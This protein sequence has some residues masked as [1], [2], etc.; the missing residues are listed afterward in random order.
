MSTNRRLAV[1]LIATGLAAGWQPAGATTTAGP[2]AVELPGARYTALATPTRIMDTR[3]DVG[4]HPRPVGS[5]ETVTVAVPGV[6]S[7][8]TAVVVNLTGTG[9]TNP[10]YLSAFPDQFA[11]TSTLNLAA[12]ETAA[13]AAV[14]TLGPDRVF[15]VRNNFGT[16]H[17]VVDLVGYLATGGGDGFAAAA[18]PVRILDTRTTTGGHLGALGP[19]QQLTLPVRG[20]A[21]VPATATSV[22]VNLTGVTP[23]AATFLRVTPNGGGGSSTLNLAAGVTRANLAVAAVGS[24]GAIRIGNL[25]GDTHV[26]VDVLGWFAPGAAGRYVAAQKPVRLLD[27]RET[28]G[29]IEPGQTRSTTLASAA[30]PPGGRT[31]ALLNVT[32]AAATENTHLTTWPQGGAQPQT[33]TLNMPAGSIVSN[34]A[35]VEGAGVSVFNN[36]GRVH[37]IVDAAGYFYTPTRAEPAAPGTPT[38][39]QVRNTGSYIQVTWA[40]PTDDGGLPLTRYTVTLEP[41]GR[42]VTVGGHLNTATIE[43]TASGQRYTVAVRATNFVGTGPATPPRATGPS[44]AMTRVDTDSAGTPDVTNGVV[45]KGLSADG[46]YVLLSVESTSILVPEQF[47]TTQPQILYVMRKELPTGALE[48]VGVDETGAPVHH[49]EAVISRDGDTVAY[50]DDA[51]RLY[52]R[53]LAAGTLRTVPASPHLFAL[54]M[55]GDERRLS[56]LSDDG[57]YRHDLATGVTEQLLDCPD[58]NGC[59]LYPS[60]AVAADGNTFAFMYQP[61]PAQPARLTLLNA[62]TGELR[63]LPEGTPGDAYVISGDGQWVFYSC[64][65][66]PARYVIRKVATTP[67][68]VP[69][70]VRSSLALVVHPTSVND[71]GSLLGFYRQRGDGQWSGATPGY[72]YDLVNQREVMLP[73]A[74]D[75]TYLGRTLLGADGSVAVAGERCLGSELECLPAGVYAVSIPQHLGG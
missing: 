72:V 59:G 11:N 63:P 69:T 57:L 68:A 32:G 38:L 58:P 50:F 25:A 20:A 31:A 70:T 43:G 23:T 46:R 12:G 51:G 45:P 64:A 2:A 18:S 1:L 27:T 29:A 71:D 35:V 39:T 47:R 13:V 17:V 44:P 14:V 75:N 42:T 54:T 66:C 5:D 30:V 24:D 19:G 60:Y 74:R 34:A 4:G 41:G 10:T 65:G 26:L 49:R 62:D 61:A 21:G 22:V 16:V 40:P 67:G 15:R 55:S 73:Q 6:P 53:D 28:T 36:S 37:A 9:G 52:L 3:T 7:D 56:W 48:L 33:S 8:A